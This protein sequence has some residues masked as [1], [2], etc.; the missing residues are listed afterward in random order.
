MSLKFSIATLFCFSFRQQIFSL[1]KFD[2]A[3]LGILFGQG[4]YTSE[5]YLVIFGEKGYGTSS[6]LIPSIDICNCHL[7]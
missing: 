1:K 2:I 6:K 5:K 4:F 7:P 3:D